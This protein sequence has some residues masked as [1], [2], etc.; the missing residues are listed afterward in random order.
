MHIKGGVRR[1]VARLLASS[2]GMALTSVVSFA[3][4]SGGACIDYQDYLRWVGAADTPGTAQKTVVVGS[5]AYVADLEAGLQMIDTSNP[6]SPVAV[7]SVDTPGIAYDAAV[8]GNYA[9]VADGA[10][11]LAVVNIANPLI[12][13]N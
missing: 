9:F 8:S 3:T 10:S 11:G 5:Y 1:S 4:A 2:M 13:D 12:N 7:G 6:A